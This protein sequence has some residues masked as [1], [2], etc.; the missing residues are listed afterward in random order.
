MSC[1][2][3]MTCTQLDCP[4]LPSQWKWNFPKA[5]YSYLPFPIFSLLSCSC[6][7]LK[8]LSLG[9]HQIA[10]TSP[11]PLRAQAIVTALTAALL[12]IMHPAQCTTFSAYTAVPSPS[13]FW[14]LS[15]LK[16]TNNVTS[17]VL[18]CITSFTK[19]L[20][21]GGLASC[22][23]TVVLYHWPYN[24]SLEHASKLLNRSKFINLHAYFWVALCRARSCTEWSLWVPSNSCFYGSI[25]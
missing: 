11:G 23:W 9:G 10:S 19:C 7:L 14:A 16:V 24:G 2:R 15:F 13:S 25:Y 6:P 17:A 4:S 21:D 3:E 12:V 22:S 1:S 20:Q 8:G 18:L 5:E